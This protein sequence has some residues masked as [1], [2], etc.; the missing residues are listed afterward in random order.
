MPCQSNVVD[1]RSTYVEEA[2]TLDISWW[3]SITAIMLGTAILPDSSTTLQTGNICRYAPNGSKWVHRH[4]VLCILTEFKTH[5]STTFTIS[6]GE[7]RI[8]VSP[9]INGSTCLVSVNEHY[10]RMCSTYR[11]LFRPYS[12][13]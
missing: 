11:K 4:A 1:I 3:Y 9:S 5:F 8:T 13:S 2:N 10:V 7:L 12:Y 6:E